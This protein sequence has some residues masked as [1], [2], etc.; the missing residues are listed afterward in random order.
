MEENE[1]KQVVD[2]RL[3]ISVMESGRYIMGVL[4]SV[5]NDGDSWE[6][7]DFY[8]EH[9][10]DIMIQ[11]VKDPNE[12]EDEKGKKKPKQIKFGFMPS[13]DPIFTSISGVPPFIN[14]RNSIRLIFMEELDNKLVRFLIDQYSVHTNVKFD[15]QSEPESK[16]LKPNSKIVGLD[17][18]P[19]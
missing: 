6:P 3:V 15:I 10:I 2:K 19:I 14:V 1:K 17:G 13:I 7:V 4:N 5:S 12:V 11:F 18:K 9:P 8:L 16:I